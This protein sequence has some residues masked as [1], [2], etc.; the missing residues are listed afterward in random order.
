MISNLDQLALV[1]SL[2]SETVVG[3]MV[4]RAIKT[5]CQLLEGIDG[6]PHWQEWNW[7]TVSVFHSC[8]MECTV[9]F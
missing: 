6:I 1:Y 2:T 9:G 3:S 8:W 5:Y 7:K 4:E